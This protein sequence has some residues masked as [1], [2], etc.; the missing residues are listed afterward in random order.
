[1][2]HAVRAGVRL[3]F[4]V[5]GPADAPPLVMIRGLARSARY[6][7]G[8]DE[9]LAAHF[10]VIVLDNRGVGRSESPRPPYTTAAMADDVV[11]VMDRAGVARAH[12]LGISL[13]GMIAQEVALRHAARVDRLV[14][15]CTTHGGRGAVRIPPRVVLGLLRGATVPFHEAIRMTAPFVISDAF[16]ARNPDVLDRWRD[17]A[18][19][20][21]SSLGALVGQLAAGALHDTSSRVGEIAAPTL[22]VTGDADRLV[23]SENSTRLA[24]RIR[25]ARLVVLRGAGHDFPTELPDET[26]CLVADFLRA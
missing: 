15:G 20:E 4:D 11:A 14:L 23:P 1:M 10:R 19:M 6:W 26:A 25:G 12:V 8:L 17:L 9:L 3:W 5:R 18:A 22:V 13:G 16:A 2:P 7:L 21:P 24:R